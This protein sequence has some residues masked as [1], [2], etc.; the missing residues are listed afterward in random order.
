[1]KHADVIVSCTWPCYIHVTSKSLSMKKS[2]ICMSISM[3]TLYIQVYSIHGGYPKKL[4]NCLVL[5]VTHL[6]ILMVMVSDL[7]TND[8]SL[9]SKNTWLV[10]FVA[11][12]HVYP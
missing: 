6:V 1:M 9:K 2:C 3:Y 11:S 8:V 12:H 5:L 4:L 7:Q 10:L